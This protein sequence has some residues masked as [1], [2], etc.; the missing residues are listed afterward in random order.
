MFL[1]ILCGKILT[2]LVRNIKYLNNI[3]EPDHRFIKRII[4]PM[5]GFKALNFACATITGI[6]L[7]HMLHKGQNKSANNA[8]VFE[9]FY[10]LA[11]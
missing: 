11:G 8:P 1:S 10:A 2:M 7:H 5:K 6:E 9:Q 4:K 3:A